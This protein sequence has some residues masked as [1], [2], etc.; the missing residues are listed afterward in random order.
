[1]T[2]EIR[3]VYSYLRWLVTGFAVL[4]SIVLSWL[5][6]LERRPRGLLR[7]EYD[8][9]AAQ[10]E[11]RIDL[12]FGEIKEHLKRQDDRA[13]AHRSYVQGVLSSMGQDIAVLKSR[14][15]HRRVSDP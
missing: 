14:S 10:R 7:R 6:H 1:M 2:D 15:T 4:C 3:Q 12:Q 5:L 8:E 9:L 13:E 11:S